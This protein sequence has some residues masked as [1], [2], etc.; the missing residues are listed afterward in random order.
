R[1]PLRSA[2]R[3]CSGFHI[4]RS[5]ENQA[6][7]KESHPIH[8]TQELPGSALRLGHGGMSAL[9]PFY[10]QLRTL[11]G[12]AGRQLRANSG[13]SSRSF[14]HL[15]GAGDER[16]WHSEAERLGYRNIDD[17]IEFGRLLD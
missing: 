1:K 7:N 6:P 13:H 16:G 8:Q 3:R 11:V 2:T 15:V 9:S 10:R 14:D 17:E 5:P 12:D 4:G